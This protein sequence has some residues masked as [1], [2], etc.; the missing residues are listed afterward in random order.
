MYVKTRKIIIFAYVAKNNIKEIV[1]L[2]QK[3]TYVRCS[4][5]D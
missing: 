5:N 3:K 2:W 1:G 4:H